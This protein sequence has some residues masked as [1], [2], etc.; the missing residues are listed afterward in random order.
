MSKG[1][2]REALVDVCR[3]QN[4]VLGMLKA[5]WEGEEQ[6]DKKG[7]APP[8]IVVPEPLK[9]MVEDALVKGREAM[10]GEAPLNPDLEP[11]KEA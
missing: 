2:D 1:S 6:S 5:R 9:E 8:E 4:L 7:F 3:Y 11:R 10:K